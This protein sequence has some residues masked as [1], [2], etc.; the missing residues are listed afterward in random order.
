MIELLFGVE[1]QWSP[2]K[3]SA[4]IRVASEE[5]PE[6]TSVQRVKCT[7]DSPPYLH[8]VRVCDAFLIK[9]AIHLAMVLSKSHSTATAPVSV[10]LSNSLAV[11]A[12]RSHQAKCLD[13]TKQ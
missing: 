4:S 6:W 7:A 13:A 8:T 10:V 9:V 2:S 11:T 5:R 3:E 12:S 1:V